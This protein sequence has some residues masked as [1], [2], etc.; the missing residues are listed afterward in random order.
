MFGPMKTVGIY[1]SD[2]EKAVDF[3]VA[4]LGF[5]VRRRMQMGA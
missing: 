2:Q 1:V 4:T 5:E 3:Y